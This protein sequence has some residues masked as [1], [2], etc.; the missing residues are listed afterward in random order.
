MKTITRVPQ[1]VWGFLVVCS[2]ALAVNS[3]LTLCLVQLNRV[4]MVEKEKDALE[5]DRNK[6]V[7]FLC[8]ENKMFKE[9]N[10]ICQYYM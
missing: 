8:L 2:V 5:A 3:A 7:E 1:R 4:K 10:H 9:K 6:A